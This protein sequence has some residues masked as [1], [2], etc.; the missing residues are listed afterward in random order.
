MNKKICLSF[1]GLV[2]LIVGIWFWGGMKSN[3]QE[4]DTK[5]INS[6]EAK[7]VPQTRI[8]LFYG[9]G[10]SHCKDVDKFLEENKIAEKVQFDNLEV[11][12]N[13]ENTNLLMEK[14]SICGI[15][16]SEIG[17]PFLFSEGKCLVGA[18]EIEDFF[19]KQAGIE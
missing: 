2:F 10:C 18:P 8:Q 11:W 3:S 19:K 4:P 13:K 12:F 14:A 17:V 7:T 9:K 1:A 16:Q 5:K 15:D 6:E